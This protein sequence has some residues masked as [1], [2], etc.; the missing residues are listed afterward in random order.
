M[1]DLRTQLADHIHDLTDP[2]E[3][4]ETYRL[5]PAIPH[6]GRDVE[7]VRVHRVRFPALIDQLAAAVEPAIDADQQRRGIAA[8]L[9]SAHLDAIDRLVAITA[10]AAAWLDELGQPHRGG[11]RANLRT[12]A[13]VAAPDDQLRQLV[14]DA[15]TWLSWARVVTGWDTPPM[16]PNVRCLA[17]G[18]LGTLRVRFDPTTACCVECGT[19]WDDSNIGL[20]AAHIATP[21]EEIAA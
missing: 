13:G 18:K 8:S 15:R 6:T 19:A 12:L 9:P 14:A 3:H 16:R 21:Q 1:T 20:L 17:C 7:E 11:L 5:R 10:G 2:Y 4:A